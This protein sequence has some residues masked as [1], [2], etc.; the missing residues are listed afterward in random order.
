MSVFELSNIVYTQYKSQSDCNISLTEEL[1]LEIYSW[2][3]R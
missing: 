3:T 2:K 1:A